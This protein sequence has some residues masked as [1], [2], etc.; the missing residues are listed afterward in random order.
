MVTLVQAAPAGDQNGS[1]LRCSSHHGKISPAHATLRS[2][3]FL[4]QAVRDCKP[5]SR[6]SLATK[7][8]LSFPA[9]A[10]G[11][12]AAFAGLAAT[13]QK[14]TC[15]HAGFKGLAVPQKR[16]TAA[17]MRAWLM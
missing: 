17:Q 1:A 16:L 13:S 9:F 8:S 15:R 11:P 4:Q 5:G 7:G 10:P 12:G 3:A 2:V 14:C 6:I